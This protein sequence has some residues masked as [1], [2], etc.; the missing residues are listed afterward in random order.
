M[1]EDTRSLT[2]SSV[3]RLGTAGLQE[4]E[5]LANKTGSQTTPKWLLFP[6]PMEGTASELPSGA[7]TFEQADVHLL[8]HHL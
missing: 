5:A 6:R 2:S 1:K 3:L 4:P 8:M 7:T